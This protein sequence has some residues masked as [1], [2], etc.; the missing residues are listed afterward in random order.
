[1]SKATKLIVD[2]LI[3]AF[4]TR[5][6]D[7]SLSEHCLT[8]NATNTSYWIAN[9]VLDGGIY[10]PAKRNFGPWQSIRFHRSLTY[11][12]AYKACH[13]PNKEEQSS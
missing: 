9:T 12:Q 11:L 5:P 2:N 3:E 13:T 7:F 6:D 4:R 8:D 10:Q 1:M